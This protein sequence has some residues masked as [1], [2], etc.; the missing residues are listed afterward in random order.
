VLLAVGGS[1]TTDGGAGALEAI[2]AAGGLRGAALE[3]LCDV[4]TPFERAAD[5]FG[6]QKGADEDT[7]HRL[8]ERLEAMAKLLPRD[9][10]GVP[11]TGCA[12]GLSGGLWAALDAELHPGAAYIL[13]AVDFD[14]R[15]RAAD[16]VITGEG[17][18][19]R[20]TLAGKLVGE[21]A[22][23]CRRADR[24]VHAIVGIDELGPASAR[25]AALES[26]RA[27]TTLEEIEA[28]AHEIASAIRPTADD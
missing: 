8:T 7:V 19:D 10:R 18:L 3:V 13:D 28:T 16:A 27:A 5:V 12:G 14:A 22:V 17:K 26:V 1:A 11:M 15:M 23:R 24:P 9:P 6:P 2:A 4:R 25:Q 21:I 20:Q